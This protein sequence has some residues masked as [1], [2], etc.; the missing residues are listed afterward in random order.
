MNT[1]L[2]RPLW[3]QLVR[4][5]SK[6]SSLFESGASCELWK[7]TCHWEEHAAK[8]ANERTK[9]ESHMAFLNPDLDRNRRSPRQG[10][11]AQ[12]APV[13]TLSRRNC[14]CNRTTTFKLT[15]IPKPFVLC[16]HPLYKIRAP[17]CQKPCNCLFIMII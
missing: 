8:E 5:H 12:V 7:T 13:L 16:N 6:D 17:P 11:V 4:T 3:W 10:T 9:P 14:N 15:D 1:N 2:H